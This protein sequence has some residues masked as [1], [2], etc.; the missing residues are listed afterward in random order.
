MA[1]DEAYM[2]MSFPAKAAWPLLWTEC[3]DHGAFDWK[4]I[5][6]KARI[7]PADNVDFSAILAELESLGCVRAVE[8]QG[9]KCGLIKN[10]CR[11]QS[12]KSPSYRFDIS[13]IDHEFI[14][15]KEKDLSSPPPALPQPSPKATEKSPQRDIGIG[16]GEGKKEA[17]QP[18]ANATR[19]DF[20]KVESACRKALDDLAPADFVIGPIIALMRQGVTLPAIVDVL[21][22][23]AKRPRQKPI[24]TW[25]VWATIIAERMAEAPKISAPAPGEKTYDF[26]GERKYA[27]SFLISVLQ[28]PSAFW[29]DKFFFGDD[30][31]HE[32]VERIAPDLLKFWKPS[33]VEQVA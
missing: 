4:P 20:D 24:R 22:S 30:R 28:N 9:K 25:G 10:F 18:A 5:V 1:S 26:G 19:E 33:V 8:I 14:A 31:F 2:S 12:P 13:T 3:D 21:I 27:E 17:A 16:E 32:A 7:F 11:Y 29:R 6:L 15:L 23:E